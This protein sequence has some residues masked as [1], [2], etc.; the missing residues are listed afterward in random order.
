MDKSMKKMMI[1]LPFRNPSTPPPSSINPFQHLN[2]SYCSISKNSTMD[3][4]EMEQINKTPN[5]GDD[6]A[7]GSMMQQSGDVLN[8]SSFEYDPS[9]ERVKNLSTPTSIIPAG[10]R[11][12]SF[13]WSPGSKISQDAYDKF[14][15]C[16]QQIRSSMYDPV[17]SLLLTCVEEIEGHM[18]P[19]FSFE[20]MNGCPLDSSNQEL[21]SQAPFSP[22]VS[23]P[24]LN[25]PPTPTFGAKNGDELD[26]EFMKEEPSPLLLCRI[27]A[28]PGPLF[29]KVSGSLHDVKTD[30]DL[31]CLARPIPRKFSTPLAITP[32]DEGII[33]NPT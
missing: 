15:G 22:S 10:S 29:R 12:R 7:S 4:D 25:A 2:E 16:S 13:S 18:S 19:S 9:L 21:V 28:S 1:G 27:P 30:E 23:M 6:S 3:D 31:N 33:F 17:A 5:K 11:H 8:C 20:E 24:N 26:V 14:Y 32:R